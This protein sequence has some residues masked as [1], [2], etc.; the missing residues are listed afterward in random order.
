MAYIFEKYGLG[1]S[2]GG[3][4]PVTVKRQGGWQGTPVPNSGVVD[5]IY[6]NTALSVEEVV[7]LCEQLTFTPVNEGLG[8]YGIGGSVENQYDLEIVRMDLPAPYNTTAYML[9]HNYL[10]GNVESYFSSFDDGV[11]H[12]GWQGISEATL[13][14]AVDTTFEGMTIGA[15]NYLISSLVSTTPFVYDA[16]EPY[17]LEGEYDGETITKKDAGVLDIKALLEEKK[18]PLDINFQ[19]ITE[20]L[21]VKDNGTYIPGARIVGNF[22]AS[23]NVSDFTELLEKGVRFI[24][25]DVDLSC[26]EGQ[27]QINTTDGKVSDFMMINNSGWYVYA[28]V[29]NDLYPSIGWYFLNTVTVTLDKTSTPPSFDFSSKNVNVDMDVLSLL[30]TD[31]ETVN[32]VGFN[33]VDVNVQEPSIIIHADDEW[34]GE[35][36]PN[37]GAGF[38]IYFNNNLTTEEITE[39]LNLLSYTNISGVPTYYLMMSSS[40][41][42]K[43]I[44]VVKTNNGYQI[45]GNNIDHPG[46]L[47]FYDTQTGWVYISAYFGDDLANYNSH[48]GV[49]VGEQNY[50]LLELFS[51]VEH[52]QGPMIS[53]IPQNGK[54]YDGSYV[55]ITSNGMIRLSEFTV[56]KKI[57]LKFFINVQ[58]DK[59]IIE[60]DTLPTE[61]VDETAL[62]KIRGY[63]GVEVYI[64]SRAERY[65]YITFS[66]GLLDVLG[67]SPNLEYRV[68]NDLPSSPQISD[69]ATYTNIYIYI[70]ENVPYLYAN[71]GAGEMWLQLTDVLASMGYTIPLVGY[72]TDI[73]STTTPG[74]YVRYFS[75]RNVAL[76]LS[77]TDVYTWNGTTWMSLE[78]AYQRRDQC[79]KYA[80]F[81]NGRA[82]YSAE[83]DD[84]IKVTEKSVEEF[85]FALSDGDTLVPTYTK[86]E[87][88]KKIVYRH[89]TG[90]YETF[91]VNQGTW[92]LCIDSGE[93]NKTG[94]YFM[95]PESMAMG[96]SGIKSSGKPILNNFCPDLSECYHRGV[97][98]TE[99]PLTEWDAA[100]ERAGITPPQ[101]ASET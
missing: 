99:I 43:Y 48:D 33:T 87:K 40:L 97:V 77:E 100:L 9:T 55:M 56:Q 17:I 44:K 16:G 67:F 101:D 5:K 41:P 3:G 75:N 28:F 89:S 22:K 64:R 54:N 30:L 21:E 58:N 61:N 60:V 31:I 19:P 11:T 82:Y 4:E 83:R 39:K 27:I 34:E 93:H 12:E 80:S 13:G 29:S 72:T 63:T 10:F 15:Q 74:I 94:A 37:S 50:L 53:L 6:F 84:Y 8:I 45:I 38:T 62:Y 7:A 57:P 95:L 76:N 25:G 98:Y 35:I 24:V 20:S 65:D 68:V 91:I 79:I 36:V 32:V 81:G 23:Y 26:K 71:T 69:L 52:V 59:D 1:G 88:T 90:Q 51:I 2:G 47:T 92:A 96:D 49:L 66:E 78:E 18:L 14:F 86:N 73:T 46:A 70:C 42:E 85:G